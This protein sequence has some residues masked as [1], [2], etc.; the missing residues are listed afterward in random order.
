MRLMFRE[1]IVLSE[2]EREAF[3]LVEKVLE[4]VMR[5][6]KTHNLREVCGEGLDRLYEFSD[7][8]DI[9]LED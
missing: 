4:G 8:V 5:E 6:C 3:E 7:Y 9:Y 1:E 2:K